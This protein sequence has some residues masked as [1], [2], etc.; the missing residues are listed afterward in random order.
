MEGVRQG[1]EAADRMA[2][3]L[4][5][6]VRIDLAPIALLALQETQQLHHNHLDFNN[7]ANQQVRPD[8]QCFRQEVSVRHWQQELHLELAQQLLTKQ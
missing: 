4:D 6:V 7:K 2:L 3:D 1:S 5:L 8:H